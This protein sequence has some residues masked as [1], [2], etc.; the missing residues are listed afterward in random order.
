VSSTSSIFFSQLDSF[1]S[2]IPRCIDAI[3]D[4]LGAAIGP[5]AAKSGHVFVISS[6]GPGA[7]GGGIVVSTSVFRPLLLMTSR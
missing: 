4:F 7:D 3:P 6:V 1:P 2:L 5:L